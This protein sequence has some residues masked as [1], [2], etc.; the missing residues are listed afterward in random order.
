MYKL[1]LL[2]CLYLF[3]QMTII[4]ILYRV[5]KNPSIVDVSWSLGL[6]VAGL[7]YLWHQPATFR[8][9]VISGLLILWALRL[10]GYLFF[11]RIAKGIVDKRYVALSDKWK[12][13]KSLGFFLNFQLQGVFILIL[14]IVFLFAATNAPASLSLVDIIACIIVLAGVTGETIADLQLYYFKQR[15]KGKVCAVGLWQYS[16]HPNYFFELLVWLGFYLFGLQ[17][18]YGWIGFVSPLLLYVIF[19]TMSGPLTERGSLESKRQAYRDY[20]DKTPMIFPR[21]W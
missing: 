15:E 3:V 16:R 13:A 9:A 7:I 18:S 8:S 4:W 21:F 14:S 10:A 20:Q 12:M 5:S 6:M 19:T 2:V 11:T 1:I 17:Y